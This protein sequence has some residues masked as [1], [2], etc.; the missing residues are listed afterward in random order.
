MGGARRNA[1]SEPRKAAICVSKTPPQGSTRLRD[2]VARE[3]KEKLMDPIANL[4]EQL[5]PAL[6]EL[7]KLAI[8]TAIL[9]PLVPFVYGQG[10]VQNAT[11]QQ[12]L[13][14]ITS[15]AD[16]ESVMPQDYV[17]ASLKK[18]GYRLEK[19]VPDSSIAWTIWNDQTFIGELVFGN[20]TLKVATASLYRGEGDTT[21][22]QRLFSAIYDN[23]GLSHIE[24]DQYGT[25]TRTRD[26]SLVVESQEFVMGQ[27]RS[28]TLKF[29]I[30]QKHFQ[31]SVTTLVSERGEALPQ[32]VTFDEV[33]V[34]K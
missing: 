26:R 25:L 11:T 24:E 19:E 1:V 34:P 4:K 23:S 16:L 21:L 30:G 8:S 28:Q 12:P 17:L 31:L 9:L 7:M 5:E 27:Y 33:I 32:K 10:G 22:V 14:P 3:K 20:G 6:L 29:L 2:N 13:K 18:I 15:L